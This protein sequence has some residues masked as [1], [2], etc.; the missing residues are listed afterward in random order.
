[1]NNVVVAERLRRLRKE[2]GVS[3]EELSN[4][5]NVSRSAICMYEAG[6]RIPR[7][8]VKL[9]IANYFNTSVET[10]FFESE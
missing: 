1:M 2:K 4:A 7:D 9:R 3:V 10:I 6:N 5:L 8:E